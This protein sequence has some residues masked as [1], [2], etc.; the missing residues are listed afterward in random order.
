M[1]Y[2]RIGLGT[3]NLLARLG[4]YTLAEHAFGDHPSETIDWYLHAPG[5]P[6]VIFCHRAF[7]EFSQFLF[8]FVPCVGIGQQYIG[9]TKHFL[10]AQT[11][12]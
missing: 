2:E 9:G 11:P 12:L 6:V 7:D 4:D 1:A 5:A 8:A 3:L 10:F